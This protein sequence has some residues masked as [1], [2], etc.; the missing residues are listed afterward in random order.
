MVTTLVDRGGPLDRALRAPKQGAKKRAHQG[1]RAWRE[2]PI[3]SRRRATRAGSLGAA[4]CDEAR[5]R[6]DAA[7][8]LG[9]TVSKLAAVTT[10]AAREGCSKTTDKVIVDC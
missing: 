6:Y 9:S 2:N 5:R 8:A 7:A 3:A 4:F 10:R 1:D